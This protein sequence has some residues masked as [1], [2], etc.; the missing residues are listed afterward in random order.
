MAKNL[1]LDKGGVVRIGATTSIAGDLYHFLLTAP[2]WKLIAM[3]LGLYVLGNALFALGYMALADGIENAEPGSFS[4]AFFFSVQTMATI[5]YGKLVPRS[6]AANLLVTF[7]AFVGLF[8]V[9]LSTG[10]MFAKFSRPTSRVLFSKVAVICDHLGTPSLMFRMANERRNQIL[11]AQVRLVLVRFE[12]TPEGERFRRLHDLRLIRDSSP[13]FAATFSVIH[14]ITADSVLH[15][16]LSDRVLH[17]DDV[18]VATF[19]GLDDDFGQMVHARHNYQIDDV[20]WGARLVDV[21]G[22]NEQGQRTIDLRRFHDVVDAPL[23]SPQSAEPSQPLSQ[24]SGRPIE[25]PAR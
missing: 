19:V 17:D 3:M 11:E 21:L 16:S 23:A 15:S 5:G 10:I 20:R 12:Q 24:A 18:I 8:G 22:T 13:F 6:T 14:P 9:A 1:S 2:W 25:P 4:H 7:E